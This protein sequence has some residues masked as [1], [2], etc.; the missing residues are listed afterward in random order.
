MAAIAETAPPISGET[1]AR[2]AR[3]EAMRL[4]ARREFDRGAAEARF[5]S[6]IGVVAAR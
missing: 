5:D 3:G 1:A 4:A 6:L 2:L